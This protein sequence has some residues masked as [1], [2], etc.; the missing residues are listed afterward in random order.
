MATAKKF[1]VAGVSTL[2]GK[3][4]IRFANDTMRIKILAKNG[5]SDV[6]LV[7]LP[8]EM[9]KSEIAAHLKEIGFGAG[10]PAVEAAIA[11]IAKKNPA[12]EAGKAPAAKA[13]AVTA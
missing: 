12:V 4:K 2:A 5:H 3:T 1:A 9:T 11:Y 10:K 7:T 6:E 13:A 8:H